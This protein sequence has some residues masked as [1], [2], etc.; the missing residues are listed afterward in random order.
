MRRVGSNVLALLLVPLAACSSGGGGPATP[1]GDA[2]VGSLLADNTTD[3]AEPVELND[4]DL[5]FSE[6]ED[7]YAAFFDR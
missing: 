5:E 4:L 3:S 2:L 7:A 6:D 1:S